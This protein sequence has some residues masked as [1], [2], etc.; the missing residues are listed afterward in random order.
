M[1]TG[2]PVGFYSAQVSNLG[3]AAPTSGIQTPLSMKPV[4]SAT[5]STS[6]F[7]LL[8]HFRY[9]D[10]WLRHLGHQSRG[11]SPTCHVLKGKGSGGVAPGVALLIPN[12][13]LVQ[14]L[15]EAILM[16]TGRTQQNANLAQQVG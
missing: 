1:V 13:C 2:L 4:A 16:G 10:T 14:I 12:P 15:H 7:L 5:G 3:T 8:D 9:K 11:P 6:L